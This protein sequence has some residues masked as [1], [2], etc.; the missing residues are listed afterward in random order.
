MRRPVDFFSQMFGVQQENGMLACYV[1]ILLLVAMVL[2]FCLFRMPEPDVYFVSGVKHLREYPV[3][4]NI[5]DQR[6]LKIYEGSAYYQELE[7]QISNNKSSN[8]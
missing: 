1:L 7:R 4:W 2:V 5:S 6:L 8:Q 3:Y